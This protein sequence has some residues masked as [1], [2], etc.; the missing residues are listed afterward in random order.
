MKKFSPVVTARDLVTLDGDE[1]EKG[2]YAARDGY[3]LKGDESRSFIHGWRNGVA[4]LPG[5]T[6]DKY[7][8]ALAADIAR[9]K[10]EAKRK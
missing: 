5:N 2:Y 3:V 8:H 4:D 6:P 10:R 9:V 1:I 7:Q